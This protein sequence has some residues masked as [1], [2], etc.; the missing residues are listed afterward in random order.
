[1]TR[2]R[3]AMTHTKTAMTRTLALLLLAATAAGCTGPATFDAT[4][5]LFTDGETDSSHAISC[6]VET[7]TVVRYLDPGDLTPTA[8]AEEPWVETIVDSS[9]CVGWPEELPRMEIFAES[10]RYGVPRMELREPGAREEGEEV[11]GDDVDVVVQSGEVLA[12]GRAEGTTF[13]MRVQEARS[14]DADFAP[15]DCE[16]VQILDASWTGR[17]DSAVDRDR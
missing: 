12:M 2:T 4:L 5:R 17:F 13:T 9:A 14:V 7:A 10:P 16:A 8:E 11:L 1:M 6:A 3:T 15:C